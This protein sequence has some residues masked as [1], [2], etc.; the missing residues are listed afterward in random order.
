MGPAG[1]RG[2]MSDRLSA[3]AEVCSARGLLVQVGLRSG[4]VEWAHL[5]N[6]CDIC[7]GEVHA[8]GSAPTKMQKC[9]KN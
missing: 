7:I 9:V 2:R 4:G 6:S 5:M 8:R 1:R 3:V